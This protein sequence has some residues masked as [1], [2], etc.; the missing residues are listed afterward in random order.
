MINPLL[1]QYTPLDALDA[2]WFQ[3]RDASVRSDSRDDYVGRSGPTLGR[4]RIGSCLRG[5][6]VAQIVVANRL[7]VRRRVRIPVECRWGC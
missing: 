5:C 6:R 2:E 7:R 3:W 4:H 1:S